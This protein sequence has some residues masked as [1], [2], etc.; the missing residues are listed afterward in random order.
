MTV[1]FF[2]NKLAGCQPLATFSTD[3]R[4]TIE[5]WLKGMTER[6]RRAPVQPISVAVNDE[7]ICPTLWHKVKFK[8]SDHVQIWREP[9]GSDP[10]S[11]TALLFT[12]VKAIKGL[13]TPK[14]PGMPST[15]AGTQG[16]PIDEASAKGNKVK[17]GDPVRNLAGRQKLYPSYLSEP[18]PWFAAPREQWTE[19]LLYISAGD[20]QVNTSDIKIGETPIISFGA[21]AICT[22]YPPGADVSG[23]TAS[24][25]WYNVS[26]V[27]ASSSG[28]AGLEMTVS[29]A[30]TQ[31]ASASAYQFSGTSISIPSGAGA[32]PADWGT[33]LI[34]RV[35][36]PYEY[37]VVDGGAGR[38]IVRG[39]LGMLNPSAGMLIEVQGANTGYY[40]VNSYTSG[41]PEMTLNYDGGQPVVGL[42]LGSGLATI[43][44]RGL[45]YRI[46]AFSSTL[47]TVE[48]LTS[49][50]ATDTGWTGFVTMET[51]N[52][53]ITLDPSNLEGGYRGPFGCAPKGELVTEIEYTVFHANGLCGIG[54]EGQIYSVRSFHA[55]EYRDMDAVG[56]WTVVNNDHAGGTRD[57]QG[58]TYRVTL[59]YPMRPEARIK[60]R[61]VSQP[62][63]IDSEKQDDISW[64]SLRSLRQVRPTTY[65]GMTVM[66]L[67]I[68]GGDR[69]SAQSESQAN[70][71]GT[72][73]LPIYTGGAWT[74]PQPTRG[75]APWCLH[76]LKSLG[77]TDADIDLPEWDRLH[78][79]FEAAGQYYDEVID[80]TSTAKDRLNN[81]LACGFAELT[82][83]N[84]LVSL[85]RDEPRAAF[86]ITYGPKTQ[87]YSPQNMTKGLKIDGPL[88]SI[89]DFDG[90]DVE[91]YSNMTWAWETVPCRWPGDAGSKVEKVKLPGVGDRNRAYRFGMRRRGHQLFRQDTYSWET[92]LAGMNSGYLSFCAVASDTPGLCQSAQLRSVTAVTGGFL[93]ESTEPIDWSVPEAYKVGISRADGSLS[94]P[95]QAT[96]IDEY[97]MQI[98]DL[99]FVPDTSMTLQLPQLLV[100]PSS[101][102]AYPVLVTSSNPSNGNVAIKGMPYDARVYTYD[103]ATAPA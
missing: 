24:M 54:R 41:V 33:G 85:V 74:A 71:I 36:A 29:D 98:T 76:A 96:E 1:E 51:V 59:P 68:R 44:P 90:V 60:K 53:L 58:F 63:N 55:F 32:F 40:V 80:D 91:Y 14:M 9:K 28:S 92:E 100:G 34:I 88:P 82:I 15:G 7:L 6:Y 2:P 65:P 39:P 50:G 86:D 48:R 19:M 23:N 101:K 5:A 52:G 70:L 78:T 75:I 30:L 69:L 46:T 4:M 67:Q 99:D 66:A 89:N 77:Y 81:A 17:L 95:F 62:G 57:A 11:I 37:T 22:I 103:N 97:H 31:T 47:M 87:T 45:R 10:F 27:G 35:L 93:L 8:P 72:R 21:D 64:Y 26:E 84:G 61:F 42:A 16:N 13:L 94:G 79:A 25:L 43:G 38:D 83:K 49:S 18:R 73:I 102:W 3:R 56:A 20:V 12:G